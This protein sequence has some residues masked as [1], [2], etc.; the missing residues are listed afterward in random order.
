[1]TPEE[2]ELVRDLFE[3]LSELERERRDPDAERLIREGLTRA[4]NAVYSL[5]QTVLLQDEGLRAADERILQLE[6]ELA[7]NQ[8]RG[9]GRGEDSFLG[10]RDRH[11]DDRGGRSSGG[12]RWNTG[13]VIG[14]G[15]S[16][17]P[18]GGQA[19]GS[20]RPMGV[21]PGFGG[22]RGAG[23]YRDERGGP[24]GGPAGGPSGSPSGRGPWEGGGQQ[25]AGSGGGSFLGTAAA[26]AAGAIGGGLLMGGIKSALG[27]H[28]DGKGPF[29][30]A[31]DQLG[32]KP[33]TGGAAGEGGDLS[34][35]AGVGDVGRGGRQGA[36]QEPAAG[37]NEGHLSEDNDLDLDHDEMHDSYDDEE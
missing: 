22:D 5:V 28:G 23:G 6:D 26:I 32:G 2:R 18:V 4:P 19:G 16:V 11:G 36:M 14:G 25:A 29:A 37:E 9:Q 15:G 1:M 31:L 35:D 10:N 34:R 27:G 17:P 7:R 20:E 24:M 12:G 8:P 13:E 3:R 30:G 33:S 21:P